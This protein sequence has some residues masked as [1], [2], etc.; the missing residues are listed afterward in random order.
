MA[1]IVSFVVRFLKSLI[2]KKE[3]VKDAPKIFTEEKE[4]MFE[5]EIP[6]RTKRKWSCVII[7]HSLTKD[8]LVPDFESIWKYHVQEKGWNSVGY[9]LALE[10]I[11][12]IYHY[13]VGRS[14]EL[15]GAHM[16][17]MNDRAIGLLLVG[18]YDKKTPNDIQYFLLASLCRKLMG[19]FDIPMEN[20][21]GHH[22][23][24]PEKTCPGKLFSFERLY[25]E[26]KGNG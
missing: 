19:T 14:L 25:K 23:F 7:H 16:L 13:R 20:I 1:C 10:L 11:N 26:I 12:G 18:D 9:N 8:G 6:I 5:F 15:D 2:P 4:R 17:G 24:Q 21:K 3:S 22:D